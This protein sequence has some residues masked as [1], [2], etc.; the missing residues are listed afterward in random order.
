MLQL[1][2]FEYNLSLSNCLIETI[3]S[4]LVGTWLKSDLLYFLSNCSLIC[5]K[6]S[7]FIGPSFFSKSKFLLPCHQFDSPPCNL[8]PC[9]SQLCSFEGC[10]AHELNLL[11]QNRQVDQ[12][13]VARS[14]PRCSQCCSNNCVICYI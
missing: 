4:C 13:G 3:Y 14:E 11:I 10:L 9:Y 12:K 7:N 6:T 8:S 2:R 1:G 5:L